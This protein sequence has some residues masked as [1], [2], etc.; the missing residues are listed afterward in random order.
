MSES[1]EPRK[2]TLKQKLHAIMSEVSYIQKD[3]RNDFHRY[4][5][6]SE[7]AIKERLHEMFV[8]YGVLFS[9]DPVAVIS[10][11]D[12]PT[13]TGS[14]TVSLFQF[15]YCFED[16]DSEEKRE[17]MFFGSGADAADKGCYKAITGAIKYCL[18]TRF[19]IPTGDDPE[20]EA[21]E[22]KTK[23]EKRADQARAADNRIADLKA[24]GASVQPVQ[25]T[26]GTAITEAQRKRLFAMAKPYKQYEI[27]AL[28]REWGFDSSKAITADKYDGICESLQNGP[29]TVDQDVLPEPMEWVGWDRIKYDG[30]VFRVNEDRS[31]WERIDAA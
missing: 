9:C 11:R 29:K 7:A 24:K 15:S 31:A 17:G 25:A 21:A 20:N 5:Y 6:A 30:R 2:L 28:L 10:E 26:N 8:K 16:V 14:E 18:T 12:R 4:N 3:K 22:K 1:I 27:K 23:E 13:K 19:L